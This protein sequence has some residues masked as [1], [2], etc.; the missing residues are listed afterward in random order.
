MAAELRAQQCRKEEERASAQ[1]QM[2]GLLAVSLYG[3]GADIY[4]M[5]KMEW[6]LQ[7]ECTGTERQMGMM[8]TARLKRA[9]LNFDHLPESRG[10]G[11][12]ELGALQCVLLSDPSMQGEV[13][14]P[15]I[16]RWK[17][18]H[19]QVLSGLAPFE[20]V[21][22]RPDETLMM[23]FMTR[24]QDELVE[25][26]G[27]LANPAKMGRPPKKTAADLEL[28]LR[29]AKEGTRYTAQ[30]RLLSYALR[31]ALESSR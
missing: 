12:Y 10:W 8:F 27:V 11:V 5:L 17:D 6:V 15:S 31:A 2:R 9:R 20:A 7:E 23:A 1:A 13:I 19:A 28:R 29:K 24:C 14:A 22:A 18:A 4:E 30:F 21:E 26:C 25:R 3:A 16:A